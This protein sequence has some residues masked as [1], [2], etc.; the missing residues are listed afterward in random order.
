MK[1]YFVLNI[2][3]SAFTTVKLHRVIDIINHNVLVKWR[4]LTA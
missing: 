3:N 4:I 1:T 2:T